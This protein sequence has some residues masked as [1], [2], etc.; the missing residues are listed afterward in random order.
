MLKNIFI[1]AIFISTIMGQWLNE[2]GMIFGGDQQES[3][4]FGKAVAISGNYA[5]VGSPE[6]GSG[7]KGAAFIFYREGIS[8]SQQAKL[9]INGDELSVVEEILGNHPSDI[10]ESFEYTSLN[11]GISNTI[12]FY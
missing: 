9:T 6:S 7:Q 4:N 2:D 5:I 10:F 12:D 3:A 8:W 11:A 1:V